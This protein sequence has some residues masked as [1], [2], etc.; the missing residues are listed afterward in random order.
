[1]RF[2]ILDKT[3]L[4]CINKN[5]AGVCWVHVM[6]SFLERSRMQK[7]HV[8]EK[9]GHFYIRYYTTIGSVRKQKAESLCRKDDKHYSTTCKAVRLPRS[10]R[11]LQ[12][13][14]ATT[15]AG[16]STTISDVWTSTYLLLSSLGCENGSIFS[17]SC[18]GKL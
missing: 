5:A 8:F 12:L 11:M 15:R 1:M 10:K 6:I 14:P 4:K 17:A 16:N 3:R 18:Q 2:Q 9:N 7:G 13:N